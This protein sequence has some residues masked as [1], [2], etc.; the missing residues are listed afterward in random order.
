MN[1]NLCINEHG[2][3]QTR[4]KALREITNVREW[5][6]AFLIFTTIYLEKHQHQVFELLQYMSTILEAVRRCQAQNLAC[7]EHD[8]E[9]P[10]RQAL[11][12]EPWTIFF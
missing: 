6:G 7:S 8:T 9:F 1:V 4:P 11:K 10:T 3:I 12:L 2:Q 5:T